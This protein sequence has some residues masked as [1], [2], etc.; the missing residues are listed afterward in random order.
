MKHPV[1][2]HVGKRVRHRRWMVGMTQQQLGDIVGIKFQQIQKYETGMNRISAS[3]LWDIAQALD[4][5]ISFFFEGFEGEEV[6]AMHRRRRRRCR[7][8]R[9]ARR[10][11]GAGAGAL[12]LRD[13]GG[14][15]PPAVRPGPRPQRRRL[16]RARSTADRGRSAAAAPRAEVSPPAAAARPRRAGTAA[17]KASMRRQ[18]SAWISGR[19][20]KISCRAPG[21]STSSPCAIRATWLRITAGRD[22]GLVAAEQH[23]HRQ[24]RQRRR[25]R[26]A[27]SPR[28][29]R[30]STACSAPPSAELGMRGDLARGTRRRPRGSEVSG[31]PAKLGASGGRLA[32]VP[33]HQPVAEADHVRRAAVTLPVSSRVAA[34][35]AGATSARRRSRRRSSPARAGS[36]G[37]CSRPSNARQVA[38]PGQVEPRLERQQRRHV[39]LVVAEILDVAEH[40]VARVPVRQPLAAPVDDHDRRGRGRPAAPPRGRISR[41]TRCGRGRSPPCRARRRRQTTARSRIAVGGGQPAGLRPRPARPRRSA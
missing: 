32:R 36:G 30:R 2:V 23:Q 8:R 5:S 4:V 28:A 1:D 10:Q 19:S 9:P 37:R 11:G 6:P 26:A 34:S 39:A 3:R 24:L 17:R 18:T 25:R 22:H 7:A 31:L 29:P 38:R 15:A 14:A 41:R 35:S 20:M 21:S 16:I 33:G 13:P 27:P 12:L 40:G